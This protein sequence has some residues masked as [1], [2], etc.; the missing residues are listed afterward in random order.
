MIT[1]QINV[2]LVDIFESELTYLKTIN[3]KKPGDDFNNNPDCF[4][5]YCDMQAKQCFKIGAHLT[6]EEIIQIRDIAIQETGLKRYEWV[7][8]N[9]GYNQKLIIGR[10]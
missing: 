6:G 5:R 8:I 9:N 7:K 2:E 10:R 3:P 1:T 4:A